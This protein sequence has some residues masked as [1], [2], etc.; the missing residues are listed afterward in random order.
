MPKV[1][2]IIPTYQR[3][4]LVNRAIASVFAQ[5]YDDYEIIVVNDGSTDDTRCVLS[6]YGDRL[7]A[8]HQDNRGLA[9]AR[10]AGIQVAQGEYI[11]F[12]DDDDLWVPQKLEHQIPL[13]V[14][15]QNIGLVYADMTVF[16]ET[17]I[18]PGT[19]LNG[20]VPPQT[21]MPWT[22]LQYGNFF[23]MPTIVVRRICLEEVGY[24]NEAL[25]VCEDYDLWLR[26]MEKW[27]A[28][29]VN[30]PLAR[31]FRGENHPNLSQNTER[32][33]R[34]A[35]QVKSAAFD[36]N[37][38]LQRLP[39]QYRDLCFHSDYLDLAEFYTQAGDLAKARAILD[40]YHSIAILPMPETLLPS[41]DS[42][43]PQPD[44]TDR[45]TFDRLLSQKVVLSHD[46]LSH[47]VGRKS[48][49]LK[50][51]TGRD[52]NLNETATRILNL[53]LASASIAD[54]YQQL[55]QEFPIASEVL[56]KDMLGLLEKLS[57]R[58]LIDI[59]PISQA[60]LLLCEY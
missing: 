51:A 14:A 36:R 56:Q 2:V 40:C 18:L 6:D 39:P 34:T 4:H 5:T 7:I 37:P 41:L 28:G 42:P 33:I 15:D 20:F 17:E 13:F 27:A 9:A 50:L 53:L 30:L 26:I 31:Y 43:S 49:L 58:Q 60:A 1:S 38:Q 46:V 21:V 45:T 11:A 52:F 55:L 3:A 59:T 22:L 8:I 54:A 25:S 29:Y 10:N 19:Y 48:I 35:I 47:P 32:M 57:S 24:F 23:P 12:L 44:F 16:N